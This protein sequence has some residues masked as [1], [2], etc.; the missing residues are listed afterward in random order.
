MQNKNAAEKPFVVFMNHI[1]NI[2][3]VL[4][5]TIKD[6]NSQIILRKML[7][8]LATQD[9]AVFNPYWHGKKRHLIF[10]TYT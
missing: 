7:I 4:K 10:K 1:N 6:F 3:W 8:T 2:S 9:L 5:L